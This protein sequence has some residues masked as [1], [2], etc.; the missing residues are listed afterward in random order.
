M[1]AVSEPASPPAA[2]RARLDPDTQFSTLPPSPQTQ[3]NGH[4]NGETNGSNHVNTIAPPDVSSA[5]SFDTSAN[6]VEKKVD[7]YESDDEEVPEQPTAEVEDHSR[8]DM[9]LDTV[10]PSLSNQMRARVDGIR[11]RGKSWISISSV[12]APRV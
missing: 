5:P 3:A 4:G 7:D 11:Y 10:C 2:K 6:K 12:C 1:A 8:Q 9:Y